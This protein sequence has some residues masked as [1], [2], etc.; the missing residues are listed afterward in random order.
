[1]V[2]WVGIRAVGIGRVGGN[3]AEAATSTATTTGQATP[4]GTRPVHLE[5]ASP[6]VAIATYDATT[7]LSG[8]DVL[9]PGLIDG[10]DTTIWIPAGMSA[11][12]DTDRTLIIEVSR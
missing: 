7:L 1:V 12:V 11:R 10:A 8:Q 3:M 2:E 9:G 4:V 6:P 5:R